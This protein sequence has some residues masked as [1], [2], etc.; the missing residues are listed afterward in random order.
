[1]RRRENIWQLR[2]RVHDM[3]EQRTAL[4]CQYRRVSDE[5]WANPANAR[6]TVDHNE[7]CKLP[8]NR[9]RTGA[10]NIGLQFMCLLTGRGP[11]RSMT[12]DDLELHRH[13]L[14]FKCDED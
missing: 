14:C 2:T 8:Q 1:M 7:D 9:D 11:I 5:G 10:S 4:P 6:R 13:N 12:A 3:V